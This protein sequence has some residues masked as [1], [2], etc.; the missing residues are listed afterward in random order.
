MVRIDIKLCSNILRL[1]VYLK[2]DLKLARV[3]LLEIIQVN[4]ASILRR[5]A[6]TIDD[7]ISATM[8][9]I[10]DNNEPVTSFNKPI[11]SGLMKPPISPK[12]KYRSPITPIGFE[13]T[14]GRSNRVTV[15]KKTSPQGFIYP[16]HL[17]LS[18]DD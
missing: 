8:K 5:A 16:N 6:K 12:E 15:R 18:Y 17:Y 3:T 4:N 7:S 11:T 9:I 14:S 1:R 2:K 10:P 13:Q